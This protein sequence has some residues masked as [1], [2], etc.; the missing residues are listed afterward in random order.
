MDSMLQKCVQYTG[1]YF[2][3]KLIGRIWALKL[4]KN[5]ITTPFT[6]RDTV[7]IL[8]QLLYIPRI[9]KIHEFKRLHYVT[10]VTYSLFPYSVALGVHETSNINE[11]Q[12]IS[13]WVKCGRSKE[14]K[15]VPSF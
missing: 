5:C 2:K 3:I 8:Q 11:Y 9:S 4:C 14:L 1:A 13:L 6:S 10:K 12:G 7:V 15:T